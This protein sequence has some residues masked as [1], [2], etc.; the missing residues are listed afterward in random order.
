[1]TA[2][3]FVFRNQVNQSVWK[4]QNF[5]IQNGIVDHVKKKLRGKMRLPPYSFLANGT[6]STR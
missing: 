6:Q 4:R 2:L 1:M 5:V 3:L